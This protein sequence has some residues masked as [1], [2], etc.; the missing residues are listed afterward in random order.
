MMT[1]RT[2]GSMV[3]MPTAEEYAALQKVLAEATRRSESL[4][5]ELRVVRTERDLL[6]EQLN[7]FKRQLFAA[8]SEVLGVNQKDMFFNEAEELGWTG[9]RCTTKRRCWGDSVARTHSDARQG[10]RR[11]ADAVSLFTSVQRV[12]GATD[13]L[14]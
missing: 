6:K 1:M 9:C 8:R 11:R 7:M 4:V 2:D 13:I 5:G 14:R 12:R 3:Q 10:H